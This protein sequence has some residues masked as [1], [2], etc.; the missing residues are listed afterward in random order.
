MSFITQAPA[1]I[2]NIRLGCGDGIRTRDHLFILCSNRQTCGYCLIKRMAT[3]GF[4][5]HHHRQHFNRQQFVDSISSTCI[6]VDIYLCRHIFM[7][8]VFYIC[9]F[10]SLLHRLVFLSTVF[11][12]DMYFCRHD[13]FIKMYSSRQ[14]LSS[15]YI[16]CRQSLSS[17]CIF[18]DMTLSGDKQFSYT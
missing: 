18:V 2:H 6:Y 7:S 13:S 16:F 11:F 1:C 15:K 3:F 12:I 17:T 4:S 8:T 14:S 9:I 10:Y 5:Q